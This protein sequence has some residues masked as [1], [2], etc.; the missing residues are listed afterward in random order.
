MTRYR[1]QSYFLQSPELIFDLVADIE[2]YPE[3]LPGWVSVR[4]RQRQDDL[5]AVDQVLGMGPIQLSFRSTARLE[6]PQRL[7]IQCQS[8]PVRNTRIEW[9][10]QADAWGG[11]H[12]TLAVHTPA[13]GLGLRGRLGQ[14]VLA[15]GAPN[16]MTHFQRRAAR[17]Y[18]P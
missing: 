1:A 4:M 15:E 7:E 8:G 2:R 9:T 17:L 10:F 11:C 5:L 3:F 13:E 14:K 12:A 16:V 18:P 6:R